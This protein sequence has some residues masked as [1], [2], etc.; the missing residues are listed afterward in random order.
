[1]LLAI[2][3]PY[4]LYLVSGDGRV[5][6]FVGNEGV[7]DN[8]TSNTVV[9]TG[10]WHHI[11]VTKSGMRVQCTAETTVG[12]RRI[13]TPYGSLLVATDP[14]AEIVDGTRQRQ[15]FDTGGDCRCRDEATRRR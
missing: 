2:V 6:F 13:Q 3:P 14:V 7:F 5:R 9:A 10:E 8:F 1:M 4:D 11:A 12:A 15:D